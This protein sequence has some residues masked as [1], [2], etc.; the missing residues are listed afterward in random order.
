MVAGQKV[1][2]GRLHQHQTVTVT[3]SDTTL[4]IEL[5]DG[6]AK[7][8]RR[9]TTQ[10]VRSIKDQR[11]RIATSVSQTTCRAS[12][13]GTMSHITCRVTNRLTAGLTAGMVEDRRTGRAGWLHG[14][15]HS[16]TGP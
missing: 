5:P 13:G 1:A 3:V 7:V 10:P 15:Q 16:R 2:L 11:P 9:T 14:E 12:P 6:D 8:V 4:A